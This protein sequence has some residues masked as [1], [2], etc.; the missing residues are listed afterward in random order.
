[1]NA[2]ITTAITTTISNLPVIMTALVIFFGVIDILRKVDRTTS[3]IFIRK[4]MFLSVG[5][6]GIWGFVVHAFFPVMSAKFIGW[7]TSPFQFEVAVAN[8]GIG[9]AGVF[10]V[11]ASRGY[12]IATTIFVTCFFWGAASGHI[13]QM[14]NTS[15]FAPG[16]AGAIFWN[17]L[18]VP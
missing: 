12:R 6:G 4:L 11:Y 2:F 9:V 16:N 1:M 18:L 8:L 5:I 17:D 14:I 10:G 13:V 15:N 3:E 7:H